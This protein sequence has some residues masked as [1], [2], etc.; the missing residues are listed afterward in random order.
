MILGNSIHEI[1]KEKKALVN[2]NLTVPEAIKYGGKRASGI[3]EWV[4]SP[5][6]TLFLKL[7]YYFFILEKPFIFATVSF[8]ALRK[9]KKDMEGMACLLHKEKQ[10]DQLICC[11]NIGFP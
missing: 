10:K 5:H 6:G 7:I 9:F 2:Y 4:N 8:N 1:L 3:R 11:F